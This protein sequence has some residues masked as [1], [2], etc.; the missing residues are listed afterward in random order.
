[1]SASTKGKFGEVVYLSIEWKS[2]Q[3]EALVALVQPAKKLF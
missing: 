2:V 1:V 3:C